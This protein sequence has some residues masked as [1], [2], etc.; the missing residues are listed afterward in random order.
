MPV[1]SV[2]LFRSKLNKW[3]RRPFGPEVEALDIWLWAA[4]IIKFG[5]GM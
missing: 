4:G 5:Y 2:P 1:G 3:G